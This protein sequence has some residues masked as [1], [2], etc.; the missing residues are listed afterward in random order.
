MHQS[1]FTNF[2]A[3]LNFAAANLP[4]VNLAAALLLPL[5]LAAQ[6]LRAD[7]TAYAPAYRVYVTNEFGGTLSVVD[8]RTGMVT[9]TVDLG[10]RPRGLKI[11]PDGRAL[12]V[13]LS[14]SPIA[15]PGV[16][17]KSLPP[18]DKS[19]DGI[20]IV[21]T[22]SLRLNRVLRGASD[23]E[24]LAVSPDGKHLFVASEDTGA[25]LMM[26][27]GKGTILYRAA[28]GGEPEGVAVS[29][30]ARQVFVTS[31]ESGTVTALDARTYHVL[32]KISVGQ[33]PRGIAFSPDGSRVYVTCE[34]DGNLVILD[35]HKHTTTGTV[36][37]TGHNARPMGVV[38]SGD[39]A[40][41]YV[42]TGRGKTVEAV[43]AASLAVARSVEVGDRP[44]GIALSPDA[45]RIY[46]AN[47]PSD[48]VSV[49]D[50]ASFQVLMKVK[51]PG[52][53]WGV[54]TGP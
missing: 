9:A 17:E 5:L 12:Y 20:G 23:P 54:V 40:M 32:A 35:A 14:G 8:G 10:K 46:T 53:P 38:V 19:A 22:K 31:E 27:A 39:G 47:G 30:D 36:H 25:A 26:D 49:I 7:G 3:A 41:I 1:L 52:R 48:D 37:F 13:A 51:T 4:P 16:D 33:R 21:D 11:A 34:N 42:T 50:A 18:P 43:D 15:G 44:W 2:C 29:P 24:Q 6:T 28:V 45:A